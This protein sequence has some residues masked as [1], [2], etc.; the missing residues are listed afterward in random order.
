V[1][2]QYTQPGLNAFLQPRI[3]WRLIAS[4]F[5]NIKFIDYNI[6][7]IFIIIITVVIVVTTAVV[8][9]QCYDNLAYSNKFSLWF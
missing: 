5:A 4:S 6:Y 7:I 1:R 2:S 8:I 9:S 3:K